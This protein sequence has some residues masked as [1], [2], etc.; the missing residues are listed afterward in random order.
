MED[1]DFEKDVSINKYRL[2]EECLSHAS[3]YARYAEAQAE[4]KTKVSLA[5]DNLE[6]V[7]AERGVEIR[8]ELANGEKKVT[9]ALIAASVLKDE[10]VLAATNKLRK[11]EDVYAKLSVSVSAFE[12][13]KS[14][15]DNLVKLYCAGYYSTNVNSE[16]K[17]NVNEKTSTD[18]RK[19]LNK[20]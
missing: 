16:T 4:A 7:K 11:A 5:K 2:D 10:V 19:K 17:K 20:K 12:H 13:R 14:E 9:E 18:I 6:L 1:L 15:L 3:I 8:E